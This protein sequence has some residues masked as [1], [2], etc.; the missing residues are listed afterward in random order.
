MAV[1]LKVRDTV[2]HFSIGGSGNDRT[3]VL[4]YYFG[5][6]CSLPIDVEIITRSR[7]TQ[8]RNKYLRYWNRSGIA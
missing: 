2:N 1:D 5:A 3:V 7:V 4:S 6:V 8:T